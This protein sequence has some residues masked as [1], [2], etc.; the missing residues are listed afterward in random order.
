MKENSM[1]NR[2]KERWKVNSNWEL[3]KIL[4][5]F[6][7]TGSSSVYV[8]KLAFELL[9]ISSDASLYIR[10]LMW[11]L[12]VFPAYQVLLI[13]YGFIFGMFD[14]FLEF[15]KKMFSKLGFKFSKKKG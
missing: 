6:S 7:V 8:K 10:F 14:F 15:E 4:L 1:I 12:I 9:G 5:V 2:L 13:F 3:F 11:I